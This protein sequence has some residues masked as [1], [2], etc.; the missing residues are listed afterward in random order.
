MY[1]YPH[2]AIL[3]ID[4]MGNFDT[5]ANT[6]NID[7]LTAN[8]SLNH[9]VLSENPTISAENWAAMLYG[10]SPQVHGKT[11]GYIGKFEHTDKNMPSLFSRVR[12]SFPD[13]YL[14]SVVNWNPINHGIIEHDINV[15]FATAASDALLTPKIIRRIAK[16][17]KLLFVQFDDVDGAGHKYTYGSKEHIKQIETTDRYIGRI[18]SA[19]KRA[20]IFDDTLFIVIA[21]HGGIRK[22]HGGYSDT[23]K[24]VTF[25]VSGKTVLKGAMGEANTRDVCAV[26]LYALGI[27]I[28]KYDANGFSSRVPGGIF[29]GQD[30]YTRPPVKK[31]KVENND[32]PAF[33]GEH[34][35]KRLFGD[36]LKLAMFFDNNLN[37][38]T[39]HCKFEMRNTVKYYTDGVMG[40]RGEFGQT[41]S[42]LTKDLHVGK[43]GFSVGAWV[44]LDGKTLTE[45]CYICGNSDMSKRD[46]NGFAF[47]I[48]NYDADFTL[49]TADDHF[50]LVTPYPDDFNGGWLNIIHVI[51]TESRVIKVY[52]NFNFTRS[53]DI[54]D[55]MCGDFDAPIFTVGN[56]V[57]NRCNTELFPNTFNIDDLL[58]F[59]GALM[60]GDIRKLKEYYSFG[61]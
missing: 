4:G 28:P 40:S 47:T 49:C 41:G 26:A 39:G 3:G 60:D 19:Y 24:Y 55:G 10:T 31:Y 14:T 29:D 45:N 48:K 56:D 61:K 20:G 9:F 13:A 30:G 22:G 33:D 38:E 21:D 54:P 8:G 25:A 57:P 18:I 5:K 44:R 37:D 15:D 32:T 35:L 23:E 42:A 11:N 59:D 6:P 46:E 7:S 50:T 2:V 27:D 12:T 51:D 17:P 58:I 34:G 36:R 53:F 1:N 16:K 43:C 52:M